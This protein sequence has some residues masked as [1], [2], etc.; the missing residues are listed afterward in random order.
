MEIYLICLVLFLVI[1]AIMAIGLIGGRS[2][3]GTCGGADYV[4]SICGEVSVI[5]Q[6]KKVDIADL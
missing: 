4:C 3:K 2:V 1:T 6:K 5:P